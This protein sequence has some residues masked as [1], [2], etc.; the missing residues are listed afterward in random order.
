[1]KLLDIIAELDKPKQIYADRK[2][3]KELTLSD[4]RPEELED[5][6]K[7]GSVMIPVSDPSRPGASASQVFYLPKMD[8]IKRDIVQNKREFDVFTF[9]KDQ[10]IKETAKEINRLYNKLYRT[11]D[12]LDKLIKLKRSGRI[13]LS[14]IA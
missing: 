6:F 3:G 9:I 8:Q 7:Q 11:M 2:P 10:D 12:A 5:L 1:M 14:S 13:Y 4:L